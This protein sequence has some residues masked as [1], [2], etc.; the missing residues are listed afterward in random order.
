M[1]EGLTLY[2]LI[3]L[4]M[5]RKV[6]FPLS[7]TQITEFMIDQ[8]YTDYFH[9]QEAIHDLIDANLITVE[10]I[11]NT[12]QYTA[13]IDGEKT[14]EYFSGDISYAIKKDIDKYLHDNAF[15]LRN[16]S[17][18]IADWELTEDGAYAVHCRVK[19]GRETVIDLT[20]N[21]T[22]EE[23]ADRVCERWPEKATGIY[24]DVMTS[25]L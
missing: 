11:R 14:L 25:L 17:C 18:M 4:Y 12:S 15:E 6:N 1:A 8:E 10:T 9:I 20:I 7:N 16:E 13:T 22:T 5:L 23:E 24:V 19:E 21:V 2:K 3:I